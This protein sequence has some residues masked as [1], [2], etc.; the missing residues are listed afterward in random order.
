MSLRNSTKLVMPTLVAAAFGLV[1]P[2]IGTQAAS[3][4]QVGT[5]NTCVSFSDLSNFNDLSASTSSGCGGGGGGAAICYYEGKAYSQGA[6]I[7]QADGNL[8]K[9]DIGGIWVLK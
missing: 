9:C 1:I 2:T 7:K 6:V 5:A 4:F 8:Y 3:A